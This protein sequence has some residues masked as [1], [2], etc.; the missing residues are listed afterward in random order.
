MKLF[1]FRDAAL[2][3]TQVW[4]QSGTNGI[5]ELIE[6]PNGQELTELPIGQD[7]NCNCPFRC[8]NNGN[9]CARY[10]LIYFYFYYN[11]N[12]CSYRETALSRSPSPIRVLEVPSLKQESETGDY[13]E[14]VG[15]DVHYQEEPISPVSMD[16]TSIPFFTPT[17][18]PNNWIRMKTA[19]L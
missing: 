6:F 4:I 14:T 11:E 5:E 2:C 9:H 17:G 12:I 13:A 7:G 19:S 18:D 8:T 10:A 1:T 3:N 15:T 16:A